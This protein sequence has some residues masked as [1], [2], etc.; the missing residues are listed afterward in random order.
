MN[1]RTLQGAGRTYT[2]LRYNCCSCGSLKDFLKVEA[3]GQRPV[4]SPEN[5]N[6]LCE[7]QKQPC[8]Q[9]MAL[10]RRFW[11]KER[12]L[13]RSFCHGLW[14]PEDW[15]EHLEGKGVMG[16]LV[17]F[18][19]TPTCPLQGIDEV[20]HSPILLH[21]PKVDLEFSISYP[22]PSLNLCQEEL[23]TFKVAANIQRSLITKSFGSL[24]I[25]KKSTKK[26]LLR[27]CQGTGVQERVAADS[28]CQE[29]EQ[30]TVQ[31][32]DEKPLT[33]KEE[34]QIIP[35][36][37]TGDVSWLGNLEVFCFILFS[38][39]HRV[40]L[41]PKWQPLDTRGSPTLETWLVQTVICYRYKIHTMEFRD[42]L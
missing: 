40:L 16:G 2:N 15:W 27:R 32:E 18:S 1:D 14:I 25:R 21:C 38:K 17:K 8:P 4:A 35:I 39:T 11:D 3:F 22:L 24:G 7:L 19:S 5:E 9:D 31:F 29:R 33:Q 41:C 30:V 36:A 42:L 12:V 23:E 26:I 37:Q 28:R 6:A 20:I 10:E 34:S 13:K